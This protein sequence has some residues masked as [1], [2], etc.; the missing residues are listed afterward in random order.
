MA[1][2]SSKASMRRRTGPGQVL[3]AEDIG[4]GTRMYDLIKI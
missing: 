1:G 3:Y 4:M 2:T